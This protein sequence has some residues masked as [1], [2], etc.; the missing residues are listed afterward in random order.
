MTETAP[1]VTAPELAGQPATAP[2]PV[3]VEIGGKT[4]KVDKDTAAAI[5]A[6]KKSVTDAGVA[7]KTQIDQLA[8]QVAALQPKPAAG[9][10]KGTDYGNLIFTD[11]DKAVQLMKDEIRAE[12]NGQLASTNAQQEFWAEFYRENPDL[13][14][15]DWL[16]KSVLAR[17]FKNLEKLQVPEAIKKLSETVKGDILKLSKKETKK[18]PKATLEGSNE[19]TREK[20]KDDNAESKDSPSSISDVLKARKAARRAG[21]QRATA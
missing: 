4:V 1:A 13:K 16:V 21:A 12:L 3:E 8:A 9:E 2:Q 18:D 17:E 14:D 20:S 11:P 10:K 19:S 5:D 7:T 15:A 6:F